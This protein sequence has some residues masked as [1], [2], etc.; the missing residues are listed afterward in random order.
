MKTMDAYY[1]NTVLIPAADDLQLVKDRTAKQGAFREFT[2][3]IPSYEEA[4]KMCA[5]SLVAAQDSYDKVYYHINSDLFMFNYMFILCLY[6]FIYM[7]K[8]ICI[9]IITTISI[10]ITY[11]LHRMMTIGC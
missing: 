11:Y 9:Y 4:N 10:Y 8:Y 1:D 6:M 2:F 3:P 7:Y 5:K